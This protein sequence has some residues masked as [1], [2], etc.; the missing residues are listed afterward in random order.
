MF[1]QSAG[2]PVELL[3]LHHGFGVD[4]T[5]QEGNGESTDTLTYIRKSRSWLDIVFCWTSNIL[6]LSVY[7]V[8]LN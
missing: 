7:F 5:K 1:D 8:H 3:C 2:H 6:E 4:E